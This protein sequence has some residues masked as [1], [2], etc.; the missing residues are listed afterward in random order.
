MDNFFTSVKLLEDLEA[1]KTFCVGTVRTNK[2]NNLPD[3]I[4]KGTLKAMDRGRFM[5]R[6]KENV[7]G[8]V[9]KDNKDIYLISNAYPVSGDTTVPRKRKNDGVVEQIL[10]PPALSGY[11]KF[12]GGVDLN[13]QKKAYYAISRKSRRWWLRIFWHFLDVAVVNAHCLYQENRER[14]FHPPLLPQPSLDGL[15]FRSS[16]IHAMCDGF[17]S[18]K[19]TGRPPTDSILPNSSRYSPSSTREH[20]T[21]AQGSVSA[22][23]LARVSPPVHSWKASE[24]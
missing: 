10:C 5:W 12:M 11:N 7:V 9:W 21:A 19:P 8:T 16:L 14:A 13:D 2:L 18:R 23:L 3:L 17:T 4:D 15:A 22:L 24:A 1:K 6:A 20:T